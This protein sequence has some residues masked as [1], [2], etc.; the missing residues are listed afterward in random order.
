MSYTLEELA[1]TVSDLASTE[2]TPRTIRFYIAQ[3][4][5]EGPDKPGR[6]ARYDED[7]LNRLLAIQVLRAD[8]PSL[9]LREIEKWLSSHD[10][11][12]IRSVAE[13]LKPR[14][15]PSGGSPLEYLLNLRSRAPAPTGARG[16]SDA[17]TRGSTAASAPE[18]EPR[19]ALG[20]D[21]APEM[22][23]LR[24]MERIL[25]HLQPSAGRPVPRRARGEQWYRVRIT[26][27][28]EL[29]VRMDAFTETDLEVLERI[30]DC[31][32]AQFKGGE[33]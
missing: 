31:W 7:H 4:L 13:R 25:R 3:G 33:K 16:G 11:A 32:N 17:G 30:A 27:A 19:A 12:D 9:T 23:A 29:S 21:P 8:D 1:Q 2:I 10:E 5:M 20:V 14:K 15:Q 6:T 22:D 18:G 26:D 28:M 24:P